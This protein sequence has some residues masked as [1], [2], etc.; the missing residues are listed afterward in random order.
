MSECIRF[1]MKEIRIVLEDAEHTAL[2]K[3]KGD[4]TWKQLLMLGAWA[5]RGKGN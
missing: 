1:F 3:V 4:L 5:D 2:V